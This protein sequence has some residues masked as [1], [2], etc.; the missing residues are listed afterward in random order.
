MTGRIENRPYDRNG[1]K[2]LKSRILGRRILGRMILEREAANG[3]AGSLER[4][5]ISFSNVP[6]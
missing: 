3:L 4:E 1:V 2:V 6:L 5:G